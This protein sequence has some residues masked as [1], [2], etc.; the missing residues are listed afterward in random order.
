MFEAKDM[1]IGVDFSC[2]DI[3]LEFAKEQP[4]V[5]LPISQKSF[6]GGN[7]ISEFVV[8][9]TP[10]LLTALASYFVARVQISRKEIKIKKGDLEIE[11]KNTDI[12]PE[13]ALDILKQLEQGTSGADE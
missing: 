8:T 9:V 11:I 2:E 13:T 7:E 12:T 10:H 1:I 3:F 6:I 4:D 5:V